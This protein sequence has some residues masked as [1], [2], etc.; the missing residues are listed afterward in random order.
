MDTADIQIT[1]NTIVSQVFGSYPFS[2]HFAG[3][4]I[5]VQSAWGAPVSGVEVTISNNL[6]KCDK[7]NYCGISVYGPSIYEEG[8]GKLGECIVEDNDIRLGD[9]SVGVL[10][11]KNDGTKVV[12]NTLSGK[13]YYGVHL[14]GSANREGFDLGSNDNLIEDNDLSGLTIKS[15]DNYSDAHIDGRMFTG[16]EGMAKTAHYWLNKYSNRN[17]VQVIPNE[18]IIDEGRENE[19]F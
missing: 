10:I 16:S 8:A 18:I 3:F 14:W 19:K 2:T 12:G 6:I 9:G 4:G 17:K 7:L 1:D 15:P 5:Q 13:V 11:R